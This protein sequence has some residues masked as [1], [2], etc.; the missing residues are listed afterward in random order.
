MQASQSDK[1]SSLP[2]PE[3][4]SDLGLD[5]TFIRTFPSPLLA[6]IQA[7]RKY[8]ERQRDGAWL[9]AEGET[10]FAQ[11][12]VFRDRIEPPNHPQDSR[13]QD[14]RL[15]R[16]LYEGH[17]IE[18]GLNFEALQEPNSFAGADLK[19]FIEDGAS[20]PRSPFTTA[21]PEPDPAA[22]RGAIFRLVRE[23]EQCSRKLG[24]LAQ[25]SN[26]DELVGDYSQENV[27][28]GTAAA[29]NEQ[30]IQPLS[31]SDVARR[32]WARDS[33]L[34]FSASRHA[35]LGS[36]NRAEEIAI[37][38]QIEAGEPGGETQE[39]NLVRGSR[40][41]GGIVAI[42]IEDREGLEQDPLAASFGQ[43]ARP[44]TN[45]QAALR[46]RADAGRV[47]NQE[48]ALAHDACNLLSAL[49]LYTELLASPGVLD[50]RYRRY[51]EELK[52]IASRSKV[53][54]ERLLQLAAAQTEEANASGVSEGSDD[55]Q[56]AQATSRGG[57]AT[58]KPAIDRSP[59]ANGPSLLNVLAAP[60]R[61]PGAAEETNLADLLMRWGSLLSTVSNREIEIV[62]GPHAASPVP[63]HAEALERILVNLVRN[64]QAATIHGGAIRIGVGSID[65]PKRG[66]HGEREAQSR[67]EEGAASTSQAQSEK[68]YTPRTI[69]LTV[70]DSG[71]GMTEAQVWRILGDNLESGGTTSPPLPMKGGRRGLGLRIVREL[72]A[73]S[74]GILTIQSWPGRGTR[75]EIRWTL[76]ATTGLARMPIG[77]ASTE[78]VG[79]VSPGVRTATPNREL[80]VS[81]VAPMKAATHT[82]GPDGF[83]EIELRAM[84]QRLHRAVHLDGGPLGKAQSDRGDIRETDSRFGAMHVDAEGA[85]WDAAA[86][87]G[88]VAKGAIAC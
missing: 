24:P 32:V 11:P 81:G 42:P 10:N 69:A 18:A 35:S 80:P 8:L 67:L 84:I 72:V 14:R 64:A 63:T 15:E 19:D 6:P 56:P 38:T 13:Q 17:S 5:S 52:L 20:E 78:A 51:A 47:F 3:I 28:G 16:S 85:S 1:A 49:A 25:A 53:L 27:Q 74:G 75:V 60:S 83:S 70:D 7:A 37:P 23:S 62:V 2:N 61:G 12:E 57:V 76:T 43:S 31:F 65:D 55:L 22:V 86:Q 30:A 41:C 73:A 66:E 88:A 29:V 59:S 77:N 39:I 4:K 48:S 44:E 68:T 36:E 34:P 87:I 50:A 9:T 54:I 79:R 82:V 58:V 71:C 40:T 26:G 21:R 46:P 45:R 33:G